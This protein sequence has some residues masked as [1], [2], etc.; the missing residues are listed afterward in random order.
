MQ[1]LMQKLRAAN[2]ARHKIWPG[3]EKSDLAFSAIEFGGEAGEAA[4]AADNFTNYPSEDTVLDMLKQAYAEEVGDVF[5]SLDLMARDLDI[6]LTGN[7]I[8][9]A[10]LTA[11]RH[12]ETDTTYILRFAGVVGKVMD[13]VKKYLRH[14]RGISGN[15]MGIADIKGKIGVAMDEALLLIVLAARD[16]GIDVF[17]AV[18]MKFNK[19]STKV[20]VPSFMDRTTWETTTEAGS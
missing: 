2:D 20:N 10:L 19:T 5:I 15:K 13:G 11:I 17:D 8:T 3:A 16:A 9:K 6:T 18:P 4:E 12:D 7:G 14:Q 1:E